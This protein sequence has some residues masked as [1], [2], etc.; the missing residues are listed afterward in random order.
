MEYKASL[1]LPCKIITGVITVLFLAIT[2]WNVWLILFA[3]DNPIG[4][5]ASL[6]S[7]L[8]L[9]TIYLI[10]YLFSPVSYMVSG[11]RLTIKR[12]WRDYYLEL[13]NIKNIYLVDKESMGWTIR[14]FGV[15]GLFGYYG[16]FRNKHFGNMTWFATRLSNFVVLETTNNKKIL[17]T[18]DNT[19]M[20]K[21]IET[22]TG[23]RPSIV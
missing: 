23:K 5:T 8:L 4:I 17:L 18:P 1:D 9:V 3:E 2:A 16:K 20:I 10:S 13:K 14:T 7:I 6:L 21:E 22:S 15:G 19:D 12:H 11:D